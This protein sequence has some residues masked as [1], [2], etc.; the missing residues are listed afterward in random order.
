[1]PNLILAEVGSWTDDRQAKLQGALAVE[2]TRLSSKLAKGAERLIEMTPQQEGFGEPPRR[3]LR[4]AGTQP[5]R[6]DTLPGNRFAVSHEELS[7]NDTVPALPKEVFA[8]GVVES[9]Q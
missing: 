9:P 1:M 3:R 4:L 2:T 5:T 6:E 8:A 7:G